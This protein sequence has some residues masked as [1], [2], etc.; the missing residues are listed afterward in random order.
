MDCGRY[1]TFRIVRQ[2]QHFVEQDPGKELEVLEGRR[3]SILQ[4]EIFRVDVSAKM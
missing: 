1:Y 2:V 3:L 4:P